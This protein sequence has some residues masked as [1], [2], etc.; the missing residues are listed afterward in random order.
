MLTNPVP[1]TAWCMGHVRY[2]LQHRIL[3]ICGDWQPASPRVGSRQSSFAAQLWVTTLFRQVREK[4]IDNEH[5]GLPSIVCQANRRESTSDH[6]EIA[7]MIAPPP[8]ESNAG[9]PSPT[10]GRDGIRRILLTGPCATQSICPHPT[11]TQ[12]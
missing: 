2:L 10:P 7:A 1:R 3:N 8:E 9:I 6:F 12:R 4:R 5:F 11:I